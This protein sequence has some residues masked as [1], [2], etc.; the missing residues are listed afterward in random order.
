L[1]II[2]DNNKKAFIL[3]FDDIDVEMDMGW[4]VIETIRKYLTSPKLITIISGNYQLYSDNVRRRQWQQYAMLQRIEKHDYTSRV[5]E[6]ENQYLLK[7]LKPG[8]RIHLHSI[9]ELKTLYGNEFYIV[10]DNLSKKKELVQVYQEYLEKMGMRGG[11][12]MILNQ[13]LQSLSVRSQINILANRNNKDIHSQI[14]A[15]ISRMQAAQINVDLAVSS[16]SMTDVIINTYLNIAEERPDTYLLIPNVENHDTNCCLVGLS[17]IFANQ[18]RNNPWL[19]FDYMLRIGY[20]R[21]KNMQLKE[22]GDDQ[23]KLTVLMQDFAG[24]RQ[25]MSLK[26][27]MALCMAFVAGQRKAKMDEHVMLRGLGRTA[28]E[29]DKDRID[30]MINSKNLNAA[31]QTLTLIPLVSLR[32]NRDN[33]SD[34]YYSLFILLASISMVIR[35][36]SSKDN[37]GTTLKNLRLHRYYQIPLNDLPV[38]EDVVQNSEFSESLKEDDKS[39]ES[40]VSALK[41]WVDSYKGESVPPYLLGRIVTRVFSVLQN[42]KAD[43]LG[44]KFHRSMIAFFNA[45]LV[46][47]SLENANKTGIRINTANALTNETV[48]AQ[49][50]ARVSKYWNLLPLTR[51]IVTCPML[52]CHVDEERA[53]PSL[54]QCPDFKDVFY[55]NLFATFN[56]YKTNCGVSLKNDKTETLIK[57]RKSNYEEILSTVGGEREF[58]KNVVSVSQREAMAWLKKQNK[59][60]GPMSFATLNSLIE[61]F[62]KEHE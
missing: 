25:D 23:K 46:E 48:F 9:H 42:I 30:N 54:L 39:F 29:N 21:N 51:W 31:Q 32:H 55:E 36:G 43:N 7:V 11:T 15:F 5:N 62:K 52:L 6:L 47:E 40:L 12:A 10:D 45:C 27:S 20:I 16:A 26:N 50:M 14:E 13:F 44:E 57:F 60:A 41:V 58:E 37:I 2:G 1:N 19:I 38:N 56:V 22:S 8:R 34:V 18:T 61:R 4:R 59:F 35:N 28:K 33:G 53:R 17:F 3:A 49:N 24:I